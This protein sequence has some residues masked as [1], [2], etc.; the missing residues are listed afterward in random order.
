M[1]SFERKKAGDRNIYCSGKR[2]FWIQAAEC[3]GR[4]AGRKAMG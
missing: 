2:G 3:V 4:E 1:G